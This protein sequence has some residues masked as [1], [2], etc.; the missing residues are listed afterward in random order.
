M[1][2]S[3]R[4]RFPGAAAVGQ[5]P[6]RQNCEPLFRYLQRNDMV[7]STQ[8][9]LYRWHSLTHT[10]KPLIDIGSHTCNTLPDDASAKASNGKTD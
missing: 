8:H 4:P 1:A 2:P 5:G 6:E 7:G 10:F 9:R 3:S